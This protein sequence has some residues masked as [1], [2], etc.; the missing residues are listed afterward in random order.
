LYDPR[1]FDQAIHG[2]RAV[3]QWQQVVEV[4]A[5]S[6][7]PAEVVADPRR[8]NALHELPQSREVVSI[9]RLGATDV[10][11]HA[12]LYYGV[13]LQH[14]VEVSERS[15]SGN[16]EIFADDFEEIHRGLLLDHVLVV[17]NS[18]ADANA[19]I[20]Q[21]ET[22]RVE[23]WV[24]H[25]EGLAKRPAQT[26]KFERAVTLARGWLLGAM[27]VAAP[28]AFAIVLAGAIVLAV[29][30]ATA[31]A[32]ALVHTLAARLSFGGSLRRGSRWSA[33]AAAAAAAP[34]QRTQHQ[35]SGRCCDHRFG[36]IRCHLEILLIE[37]GVTE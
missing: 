4:C 11:G 9:E 12:M 2:L 16:H 35:A 31:L 28:L 7:A 34:S 5:V 15:A 29:D 1:S 36:N 24:R 14:A 27:A 10:Q 20:G 22:W 37:Y 21:L 6:A 32:F 8:P 19:E 23:F 3:R 17:G 18:E 33:L 25:W 30:R 26:A 13:A